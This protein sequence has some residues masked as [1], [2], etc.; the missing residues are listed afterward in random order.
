MLLGVTSTSSSPAMNSMDWSR[1]RRRGP[2]GHGGLG[3]GTP[4]VGQVF[5]LGDVHVEIAA[6]V[7]F[8]DNHALVDFRSGLHEEFPRSA[9]AKLA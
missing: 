9:M 6:P 2:Q 3:G 8:T 7:S 5:F 1:D 4:D